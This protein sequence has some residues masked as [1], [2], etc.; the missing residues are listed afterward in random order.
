MNFCGGRLIV[1]SVSVGFSTTRRVLRAHLKNERYAATRTRRCFGL[2]LLATCSSS[3]SLQSSI[4]KSGNIRQ[5]RER[6]RSY[7]SSVLVDA[8]PSSSQARKS[9]TSRPSLVDW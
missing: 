2:K 3:P 4:G 5:P 8:P 7:W 6:S 9:A 1:G